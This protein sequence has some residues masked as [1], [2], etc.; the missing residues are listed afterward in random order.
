M[1][2]PTAS[3]ARPAAARPR[4]RLR[5]RSSSRSAAWATTCRARP[6]IRSSTRSWRTPSA[7][8]SA[9]GKWQREA[10]G[11]A[12]LRARLGPDPPAVRLDDAAA[13]GQPDAAALVAVL[14]VQPVERPEDPVGLGGCDSDSRVLDRHAHAVLAVRLG[15]HP[16]HGLCAVRE[17]HRVAD[18]VLE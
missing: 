5:A 7:R 11:R 10:E 17:L 2:P 16:H 4:A 6:G 18:E 15:P 9:G 13:D 8:A 3:C 12:A 1:A 14:A